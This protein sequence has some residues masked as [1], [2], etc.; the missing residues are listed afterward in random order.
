M[1]ELLGEREHSKASE[2]YI[3]VIFTY[4]VNEKWKGSVPIVYR[5]T[6][7][8]AKTK[9]EIKKVIEI[10]YEFMKP[11]KAKEWIK[12]QEEFW[13]TKKKAEVTKSFFDG[14]IDSEW[15]CVNCELPKNP[16]W[17]RRTQDI[18]QFGYTLAT[19][20][21]MYCKNCKKN[22]T[23]LILLKLPRGSIQDYET[24]SVSLRAKIL[25]T[26]NNHDVYENTIREH[27]LPDHKFPEIRWDNKTKEDNS[28]EMNGEEIK[29]KFQLLNNQRNEQ[30][31][32]VCRKCFQTNKRGYPFGIKF[33]YEGDENWG[34]KIP[35]IGKK[36]EEGCIGCGWYDLEKWRG[37]LNK[38]FKR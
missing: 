38:K 9:E 33:F 5:R 7:V 2:K 16:N 3:D 22:T 32:E 10:A 36:A 13:K 27:L 17:A 35:K 18:K 15:K 25:K 24:W 37:E 8:N 19:N 28:E 29:K 31:R 26:L 6:G 23:H 14:L 12:Q 20:T 34:K 30:K 21:N 1:I 11:E 4:S